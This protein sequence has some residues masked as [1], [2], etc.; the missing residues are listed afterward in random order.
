MSADSAIRFPAAALLTLLA[1]SACGPTL[2]R[3]AE[4]PPAGPVA[5]VE[6]PSAANARER[7]LEVHWV[8]SAAEYRALTLQVYRSAAD[9]LRELAEP[10]EPGSWAVVMDADETVL[11]NS[12]FQRR[13][14]ETGQTF[15]ESLWDDWVLEENA[16][17][18]PGAAGFIALVQQLGGRVAIVTNRDE[19]LCPATR[20]NL[21]ALGVRPMVVLCQAETGEKEPR[22]EMVQEG[23]AAQGVGPLQ[24]VMWVGDNV[25]DFPDLDQTLRDRAE[26]AF[27]LFGRRYFVI[28]NPMYGSWLGNEWR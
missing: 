2:P 10:L 13:I 21:A 5:T 26:A 3:P 12:E 11:D 20:R 16:E 27:Q 8:R 6:P 24:V 15:E 7:H 18:V 9:Q 14:A 22:F 25:G 19:R 28:P 23:S 4:A 1:M 17:L